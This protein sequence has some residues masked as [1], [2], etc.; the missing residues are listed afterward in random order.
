MHSPICSRCQAI[1]CYVK[2]GTE[3]VVLDLGAFAVLLPDGNT[4]HGARLLHSS[5][6]PCAEEWVGKPWSNF[7]VSGQDSPEGDPICR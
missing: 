5:L 2:A 4:A 7:C 1:V 6:C 3:V